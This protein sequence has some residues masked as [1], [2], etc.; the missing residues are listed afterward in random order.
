MSIKVE[1]EAEGREEDF[2]VSNIGK[3]VKGGRR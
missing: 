2:E 3:T 1:V